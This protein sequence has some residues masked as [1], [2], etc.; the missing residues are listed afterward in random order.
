MFVTAPRYYRVRQPWPRLW[1]GPLEWLSFI[2]AELYFTAVKRRSCKYYKVQLEYSEA[3]NG[4]REAARTK[5]IVLVPSLRERI[6][7]REASLKPFEGLAL[8]GLSDGS[9]LADA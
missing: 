2:P 9:G 6:C 1:L 5:T 7:S 4:S 3:S 8:L